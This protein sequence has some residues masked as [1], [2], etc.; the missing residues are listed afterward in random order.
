MRIF[1]LLY[2]SLIFFQMSY[3]FERNQ[4]ERILSS[5]PDSALKMLKEEQ[6]Q[7]ESQHS[8]INA[9]IPFLTG[10]IFY[11]S[12]LFSMSLMQFKKA[13]DIAQKE[14]NIPLL[15]EIKIAKSKSYYYLKQHETSLRELLEAEKLLMNIRNQEILA[16]VNTALGR[17]Y[18][19]K[20]EF[21]TSIKFQRK[22]LE[23]FQKFNNAKGVA[24]TYN[25][26]GAVYE[27]MEIH[28]SAFLYFHKAFTINQELQY[29]DQLV[30]NIN[31]IGD[32]Y[33]K[34]GIFDS[35]VYFAN[36]AVM[37]A[38]DQGFKYQE[39]TALRDLAKTY[40]LINDFEKAYFYEK[41]S[42]K[43]YDEVYNQDFNEQVALMQTLYEVEAKNEKIYAL[44]KEK[45][46]QRSLNIAASV[47]LIA[48]MSSFILLFSRQ[49]I[50]WKIKQKI[51]ENEKE[52]ADRY[53]EFLESEEKR[54]HIELKHKKLE[55]EYLNSEYYALQKDFSSKIMKAV[56]KENLI[57]NIKGLLVEAVENP[58]QSPFPKISK[59]IKLIELN[60][61]GEKIWDDLVENF[62]Y[63]NKDFMDKL[64]KIA[65]TLSHTEIKHCALIR[66]HLPL[67]KMASILNVTKDSL[68]VSRYRIKKKLHLGAEVELV[69]FILKV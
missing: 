28:D 41:E 57:N 55:E 69:D 64:Q 25:S 37:L 24:Q 40:I 5:H 61:S 65:P 46:L 30:I 54:L 52:I 34:R 47:A 29:L 58:S 38:R 62:D 1:L 7:N 12:G 67:D 15:A 10:M 68:R 49:K 48:L 43:V 63:L 14:N 13:E 22:A 27:D 32:S 9:E 36:W 33:R 3:G 23:L 56:E 60:H 45:K 8:P 21:K 35:A 66:Q 50:K 20:A 26:I 4:V 17:W 11:N 2:V 51:L 42:R 31:N 39:S 53:K 6:Y 16:D 18:E 19:K 44:E 59:S